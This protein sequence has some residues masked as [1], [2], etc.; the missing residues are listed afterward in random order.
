MRYLSNRQRGTVVGVY[1][2]AVLTVVAL[3][4]WAWANVVAPIVDHLFA[5][6]DGRS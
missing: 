6:R 4:P 2:F 1:V 3:A 5:L